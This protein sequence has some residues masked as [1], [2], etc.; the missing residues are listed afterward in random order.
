MRVE[1]QRPGGK[2][3]DRQPP[4]GDRVL[5]T[6][7]PTH[8]VMTSITTTHPTEGG[9]VEEGEAELGEME[10]MVGGGI[11]PVT[12]VTP[13]TTPVTIPVILQTEISTALGEA[14]SG[15]KGG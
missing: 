11:L 14:G 9:G 10:I 4:P 7:H 13:V 5:P 3:K 12:P 2:G 1:E 6:V 8:L 15:T